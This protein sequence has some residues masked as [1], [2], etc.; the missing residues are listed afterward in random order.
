MR[1]AWLDEVPVACSTA[2]AL[3]E[4]AGNAALL[5]DPLSIE[6]IAQAIE[7]INSDYDLG[8]KLKRNGSIRL[9]NFSREKAAKAY[10]AVYRQAAG[11]DLSEEDRFLQKMDQTW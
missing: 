10:R 2:T 4:Q 11:V 9:K 8:Q 7:R 5:F 6:S 1:E 3:P